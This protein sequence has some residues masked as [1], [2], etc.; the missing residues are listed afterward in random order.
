MRIINLVRSVVVIG[1]F[2]ALSFIDKSDYPFSH[3]IQPMSLL[4]FLIIIFNILIWMVYV[5]NLKR[6][7]YKTYSIKSKSYLTVIY[8]LIIFCL[9][10]VLVVSS[11]Y[12]DKADIV[13]IA[14]F[15]VVIGFNLFLD[16][17]YS[18]NLNSSEKDLFV[19]PF[20]PWWRP[21]KNIRVRK[22]DET[23]EVRVELLGMG[24]FFSSSIH[25]VKEDADRF[26]QDY[27][28]DLNQ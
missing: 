20:G 10:V 4:A 17:R 5:L 7:N 1:A 24:A 11:G 8:Q 19:Y 13:L 23:G 28:Q 15:A 18:G 22:L 9:L 2:L 25:I 3:V 6:G 21:G 12:F 27:I 14:L 26:L 16:Y